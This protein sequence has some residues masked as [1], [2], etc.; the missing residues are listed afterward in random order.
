LHCCFVLGDTLRV[1]LSLPP[2]GRESEGQT[3]TLF[4]CL[5]R[6]GV[7]WLQVIQSSESNLFSLRFIVTKI[8]P[9]GALPTLNQCNKNSYPV[10]G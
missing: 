8:R 1:Y 3:F 4:G 10:Y 9:P 5:G 2:R 7:Y 6:S